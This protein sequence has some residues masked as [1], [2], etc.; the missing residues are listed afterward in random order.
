M[1]D[2]LYR[3]SYYEEHIYNKIVKNYVYCPKTNKEFKSAI[4]EWFNDNENALKK[5]GHISNWDTCNITDMIE[6][7]MGHIKFNE[8]ISRWNTSNVTNMR[9]MFSGCYAFNQPIG[10]WDVSKVKNMRGMF[11]QCYNFNQ[12]LNDWDMS[13]VNDICFM[14]GHCS[15]FNQDLTNWNVIKAHTIGYIYVPH[16]NELSDVHLGIGF[17]K[18]EPF[19]QCAIIEK[20]KPKMTLKHG[21]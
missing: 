6:L 13:N 21:L 2:L 15:R 19:S 12:P 5:Y 4:Y 3:I 14:F 18:H 17:E 16:S 7:F 9:G 11:W 1:K 20:Y 10:C 8:D